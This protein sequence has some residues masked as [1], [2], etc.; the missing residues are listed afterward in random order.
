M[1]NNDSPLIR[2]M[3][4]HALAYCERLFYL[5]EVEELYLADEQVYAGRELHESLA[6]GHPT[7]PPDS[8]PGSRAISLAISSQR[9]GLVGRVDVLKRRDGM[10][11]P[12]EHKRGRAARDPNGNPSAWPSDE[13]QVVAYAMMIEDHMGVSVSEARVRYHRDG[14]TVRIPVDTEARRA[15]LKAI[16]RA[17]ELRETLERPPVASNEN[18]C[19]RCS[20]APVCLPEESRQAVDPT[21]VP[22]RLFP[23]KDT[24]T[25]LH[26]LSQG[27][28]VGRD[29]E[30][31]VVTTPEGTIRR[32]S[33][34]ISAV[35]LHGMTQ[36]STQALRLCAD[37]EIAVHWVTQTGWHVGSF[38]TTA[39]QVQRRVRQYQALYGKE[40][41]ALR[42]R[43]AK[44]LVIARLE[45][46]RRYVLRATRDRPERRAAVEAAITEIRRSVRK[47][48]VVGSIEELRGHEGA[49]TR[50]Y[51]SVFNELLNED[52]SEELRYVARTRR[53]ATDRLSA[54]LNFGYGLLRTAVMRGVLASGLEPALGF[55]HTPRSAAHPLV[56]DLMELFRLLLWDIPLIGALNRKQFEP[57]YDFLNAGG[58]IWLSDTGRR[59]VIRI[60]ESRLQESWK[61]PVVGYSLSYERTI[62]LEARLLEKEWSG[63][64]GLFAQARIR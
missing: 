59:K 18:L 55:Y 23:E 12:Y 5:E 48:S 38:T 3:G 9:L 37:R 42:L 63:D 49:A 29:A 14:V 35:I 53:P 41:D 10:L 39:G 54:L 40:G 52:V 6:A 61:H 16:E 28:K 1:S 27:A 24:R 56:L 4:L 34:E 7:P 36:I 21:H 60:F 2:A 46:Q 19:R 62:E 57:Q 45:G 13:I 11:I 26:V 64:P 44:A 47:A 32:P 50:S 31:L 30:S 51:W 8:E 17:R 22:K 58:A 20:L 15:V 33:G 25:T 43:L